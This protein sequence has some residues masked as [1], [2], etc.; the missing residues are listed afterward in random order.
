MVGIICTVCL[1][2]HVT[3]FLSFISELSIGFQE[4]AYTFTEDN[5][6]ATVCVEVQN[7]GRLQNNVQI[8]VGYA[9]M[10]GTAVGERL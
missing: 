3:V 5:E 9:T 4:T 2:P 7:G 10:D 8:R 1:L 6:T